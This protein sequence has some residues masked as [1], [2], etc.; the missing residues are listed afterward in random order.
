M[1]ICNHNHGVEIFPSS[2]VKSLACSSSFPAIS[3]PLLPYTKTTIRNS[4]ASIL[5]GSNFSAL[6]PGHK[7]KCSNRTDSEDSG[8]CSPS[9][10]PSSGSLPGTNPAFEGR[11]SEIRNGHPITATNKAS[12]NSK[13]TNSSSVLPMEVDDGISDD[14][15]INGDSCGSFSD[16]KSRWNSSSSCSSYLAESSLD[17]CDNRLGQNKK[18]S[19]T[20][21]HKGPKVEVFPDTKAPPGAQLARNHLSSFDN[22]KFSLLTSKMAKE[23]SLKVSAP[24]VESKSFGRNSNGLRLCAREGIDSKLVSNKAFF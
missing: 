20:A 19:F 24:Q 8:V 14:H 17:V 6:A 9:P 21:D 4:R 5:F 18:I 23:G 10:T 13:S 1:D 11:N 2:S 12:E 16:H 22:G 15:S 7:R 3:L